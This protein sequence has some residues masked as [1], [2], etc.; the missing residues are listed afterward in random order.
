MTNFKNVTSVEKLRQLLVQSFSFFKGFR[1]NRVSNEASK[2]QFFLFFLSATETKEKNFHD[3]FFSK[4]SLFGLF[5]T[6]LGS[7]VDL[8]ASWVEISI[9]RN[10]EFGRKVA[11]SKCHF[12]VKKI[13]CFVFDDFFASH[14]FF[15]CVVQIRILKPEMK[16]IAV[17]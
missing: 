14:Q 7:R 6:P 5:S 4:S 17:D 13:F 8:G 9:C 15:L 3:Y 1:T 12:S 11:S 16:K 10:F 2:W